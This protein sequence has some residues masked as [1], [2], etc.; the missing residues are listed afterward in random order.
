VT[1]HRNV[2]PNSPQL[3]D[4]YRR[5]DAFVLPTQAECLAVVLGEA[6]A[7][8]LPIITTPVGAHREAVV[9]GETGFLVPPRDADALLAAIEKLIDQPGLAVHM[10]QR[11]RKRGEERFDAHKNANAIGDLILSAADG[12][13]PRGQ[14]REEAA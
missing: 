14:A 6:M 13:A 7:A 11:G 3:L 1:A 9:D 2:G 8:G 5:A 10:G 4:L 12:F